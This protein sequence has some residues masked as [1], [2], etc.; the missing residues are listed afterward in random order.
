MK[1]GARAPASAPG[2]F[3]VALR[4]ALRLENRSCAPTSAPASQSAAPERRSNTLSL[5]FPQRRCGFLCYIPK[6]PMG[7]ITVVGLVGG[8]TS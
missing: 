7:S 6:I 4:V 3:G 1:V 5:S 8:D 2:F